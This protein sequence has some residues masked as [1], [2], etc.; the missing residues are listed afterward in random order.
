VNRR[1]AKNAKKS[2]MIFSSVVAFLAS[3]RFCLSSDTST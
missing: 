1:D 2:F 3:W